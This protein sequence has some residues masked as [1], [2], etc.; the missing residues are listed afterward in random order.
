[1]ALGAITG[2]VYNSEVVGNT[3]KI[4]PDTN[5]PN[6]EAA[7]LNVTEAQ[8]AITTFGSNSTDNQTGKD[9]NTEQKERPASEKQIKNAVSKANSSLRFTRCEFTYHEETKRISIKV[10]DRD[11]DQVIREIPPEDTLEMLQKMWEMAGLLVDERR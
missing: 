11:T 8:V 3:P 1:M 10:I 7:N 2:S 4:K 9:Q 6:N 5:Y